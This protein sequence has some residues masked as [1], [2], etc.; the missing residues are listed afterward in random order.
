MPRRIDVRTGGVGSD[1]LQLGG[2]GQ[3]VVVFVRI[4]VEDLDAAVDIG[5]GAA[6][7]G[8]DRR[9]IDALDVVVNNRSEQADGDRTAVVVVGLSPQDQI[10]QAVVVDEQTIDAVGAA[11][12][13]VESQ[14]RGGRGGFQGIGHAD[15]DQIVAGQAEY[16]ALRIVENAKPWVNIMR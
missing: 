5:A 8:V 1:A 2:V 9:N 15:A 13:D 6:G 7:D 16:L 4:G 12:V 14:G 10:A 3:R 11:A